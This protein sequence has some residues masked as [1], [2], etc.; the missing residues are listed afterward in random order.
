MLIESDRGRVKVSTNEQNMERVVQTRNSRL[1][2]SVETFLS[3]LLRTYRVFM[4]IALKKPQID[5]LYLRQLSHIPSQ[6]RTDVTA[7]SMNC[8]GAHQTPLK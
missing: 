8:G 6:P 3:T 2:A 4:G 1:L 7:P 5:L